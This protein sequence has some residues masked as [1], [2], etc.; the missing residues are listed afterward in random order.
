MVTGGDADTQTGGIRN[1][2]SGQVTARDLVMAGTVNMLTGPAPAV[3]PPPRELRAPLDL[4]TNRAVE[5]ALLNAAISASGPGM[6]VFVLVGQGG[7]GKTATALQWLNAV[8]EHYPDGHFS[9]DLGG[10]RG[11]RLP[12]LEAL[13][14]LLRSA[15]IRPD[16]LAATLGERA[17]QWRTWAAG[18]R[19]AMLVEDPVT[20]AQLRPLLPNAPGSVVVVTSRSRLSSLQVGP[21]PVE[22]RLG[23]LADAAALELLIGI[24]G[25]RVNAEPEATR[26]LAALCGG[27]PLTLLV[28]GIRLRHRPHLPV[29]S[30]VARLTD[31]RHR[32][33]A[34]AAP[35]DDPVKVVYDVAYQE[36]PA[37]VAQLYRALGS[38]PGPEFGVS[39]AAAAIGADSDQV[40]EWLE[41]LSQHNLVEEVAP[42]RYRF[43]SLCWEHAA[44]VA[45]AEDDEATRAEVRLAIVSWYLAQAIAADVQVTPE[46][47]RI[48]PA[49][50]K[51]PAVADQDGAL[52]WLEAERSN[53][54][55][56]VRMAAADE[57]L[58]DLSW[59]LCQALWSLFFRNKHH[60]DGVE[61]HTLGIA[62]AAR[63]G[64]SLVEAKLRSQR[65]FFSL[66]MNEIAAAVEDFTLAVAAARAAGDRQAESTALESLGLAT[67]GAG[68]YAEAL[69]W[70]DQ[71]SSVAEQG[72]PRALALLAHHRGRALSGLGR[73]D[74]ARTLFQD[75]L[76][77][78][79]AVP[80]PYNEARVRTSL[81]EAELR[82]GETDAA[83]EPLNQALAG[84]RRAKATYEVARI[85]VLV[86]VVERRSGAAARARTH[87]AEATALFEALSLTATGEVSTR[88]AEWGEEPDPREAQ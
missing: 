43:H 84:M 36:L 42:D 62:V 87:L 16:A 54:V 44:Q 56:A 61:T 88:L 86:A 47:W 28:A 80:D 30:M 13:G 34:M 41:L 15:G 46:R 71:A 69:D 74:Q 18:K 67:L 2:L 75:A 68:R 72:N 60:Q 22:V 55:A 1:V 26:E 20:A 37:P 19:I 76:R 65:G 40:Q 24:A 52:A 27:L 7:V 17:G 77:A 70:L 45:A 5:L 63:L 31:Q 4:F 48:G 38:H 39:V 14:Q 49:Y 12:P 8:G 35:G 79:A 57:R 29:A 3:A 81:G 58:A 73:H 50:P 11:E 78:L 25:G 64:N 6:K 9:V 21:K 85:L 59:Q 66:G 23:P 53:L 82:A 10:G 32:L 33:L 51:P 83:R